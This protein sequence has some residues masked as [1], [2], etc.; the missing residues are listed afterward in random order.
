MP[1]LLGFKTSLHY[2]VSDITEGINQSLPDFLPQ[3]TLPKNIQDFFFCICILGYKKTSQN[4]ALKL[5]F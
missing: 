1:K 4:L 2:K 3:A 5:Q